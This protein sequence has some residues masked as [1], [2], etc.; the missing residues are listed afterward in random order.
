V[1]WV[2]HGGPTELTNLVFACARHHAR[3][4]QPG[5]RAKLLPDATLEITEPNGIVRCT[6]PPRASPLEW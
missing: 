4:H 2:G 3:L 6:S 1:V 5:W